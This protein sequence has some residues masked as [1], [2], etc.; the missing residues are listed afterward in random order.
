MAWLSGNPVHRGVVVGAK[1]EA[2]LVMI[3]VRDAS[4]TTCAAVMSPNA[5]IGQTAQLIP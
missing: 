5:R 1:R 3:R 2:I 4:R